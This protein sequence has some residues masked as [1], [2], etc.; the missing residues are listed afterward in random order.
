MA[1]DFN[2]AQRRALVNHGR[3]VPPGLAANTFWARVQDEFAQVIPG[4]NNPAEV[5][6]WGQAH[7]HTGF[8]HRGHLSH[9]DA[10]T[11]LDAVHWKFA[12]FSLWATELGESQWS[13]PT[14]VVLHKGRALSNIFFWHLAAYLTCMEHLPGLQRPERILEIGT[15][16]GELARIWKTQHPGIQYVLIDLPASL[17]FADVYLRANFPDAI[18]AYGADGDPG[19]DFWMLP[20][21]DWY[22]AFQH[23]YGLAVN[24]GSMQEMTDETVA[25]WCLS[26]D[27]ASDIRAFYSMN[28]SGTPLRLESFRL[29]HE[30]VAPGDIIG[31]SMIDKFWVRT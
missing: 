20:V 27:R 16:I 7:T 21:Q 26:L 31:A 11:M 29:V 24:Q 12:P 19:A 8:N 1:L 23:P 17:F 2:D 14:T 3:P 6:H 25:A 10:E 13:D 4:F 28:G 22:V 5:I 15:G 18:F 30:A 9:A